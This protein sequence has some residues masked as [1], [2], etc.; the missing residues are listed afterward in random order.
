MSTCMVYVLHGVYCA[1]AYISSLYPPTP[2]LRVSSPPSL[3]LSP[4]SLS[5]LPSLSPTYTHGQNNLFTPKNNLLTTYIPWSSTS[6]KN[7]SGFPL[8]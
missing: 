1:L 6:R 8:Q 4:L 2:P 5:S 7:R 3:P